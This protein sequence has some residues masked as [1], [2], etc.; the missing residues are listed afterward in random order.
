VV[1]G[2]LTLAPVRP[3][4]S[5]GGV[6]WVRTGGVVHASGTFSPARPGRK[7]TLQRK[8]GATWVTLATGRLDGHSRYAVNGR[9]T[10]GPG[11]A[12]LR[13]V[14]SALNGAPAAAS[15]VHV[16]V[17]TGNP[18]ALTGPVD[19][20]YVGL[21]AS[22]TPGSYSPVAGGAV[23]ALTDGGRVTSAVPADGPQ[24]GTEL[25]ASART[26]VYAAH[27][28]VIDVA[29]ET[30][31]STATLRQNSKGQLVMNGVPYGIVDPLNGAT[32]SG[33]YRR[34]SGGSG[35]TI[36]FHGNGRFDDEGVTGDTSLVGTDN[37]SGTGSYSVQGNTLSLV[38]DA[39]PFETL[40]VYAL[41]QWLGSKA[42]LVLG[43]QTFKRLTS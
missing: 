33:V 30:D 19:A 41:P 11:A 43:G 20:I 7:V 9:V 42:Q 17:V 38:Y 4:I 25:A 18:P 16:L 28:G 36:T 5:V 29:W 37:P 40:A 12:S 3:T 24:V 14:A 35:S 22:S 39:G 23:L 26:G 8:A 10:V 13:V 34:A 2:S 27:D 31:G 21:K 32:L 15:A 6:S 1:S